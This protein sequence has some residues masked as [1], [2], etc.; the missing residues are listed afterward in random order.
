MFRG[1]TV[2]NYLYHS[3]TKTINVVAMKESN[4]LTQ[5]KFFTHA[6]MFQITLAKRC[7]W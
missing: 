1:H 2:T 3:L 5:G 6:D 7:W 4:E